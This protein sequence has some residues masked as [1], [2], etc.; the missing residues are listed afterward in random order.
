MPVP[1]WTQGVVSIMYFCSSQ[2]CN[3]L[4]GDSVLSSFR[5]RL[6][7]ILQNPISIKQGAG[8]WALLRCRCINMNMHLQ[9][10]VLQVKW[11]A[12]IKDAFNNSDNIK[13]LVI[14]EFY[15]FHRQ[16]SQ[17]SAFHW[18][19]TSVSAMRRV[20][21]IASGPGY[22]YGG[23]QIL[24]LLFAATFLTSH[25]AQMLNKAFAIYLATSNLSFEDLICNCKPLCYH[26]L[27]HTLP[28]TA[29]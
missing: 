26:S 17:I 20:A 19:N 10:R 3:V 1:V 21:F 2:W 13:R 7:A 14:L 25:W 15:D 27:Y 16:P 11:V 4:F 8:G 23:S 12:Q 9:Y 29:R 6:S 5:Q 18:L 24:F 22:Y 28:H